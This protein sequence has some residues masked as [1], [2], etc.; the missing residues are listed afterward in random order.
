M[1]SPAQPADWSDLLELLTD[2]FGRL[3]EQALDT[4]EALLA[5]GP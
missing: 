4:L 5:A 3:P 1:N 2:R